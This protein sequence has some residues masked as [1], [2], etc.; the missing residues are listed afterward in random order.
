MKI[1]SKSSNI[2]IKSNYPK[3]KYHFKESG[4]PLEVSEEHVEKILMNSDFY[5][6]NKST[7]KNETIKKKVIKKKTWEEE[8]GEN[9]K[10]DEVVDIVALFPTRGVLL[11]S[12]ESQD[13]NEKINLKED[14]AKKLEEVF[15]H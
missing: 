6:S 14:I 11:K 2:C 9:F 5:E 10:I 13:F 3:F 4:I 8:L 7:K 1:A 12:L 15:V